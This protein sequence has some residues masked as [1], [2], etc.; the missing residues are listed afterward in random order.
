MLPV[1]PSNTYLQ[2]QWGKPAFQVSR[3]HILHSAVNVFLFLFVFGP[4][5]QRWRTVEKKECRL[6]EPFC[7]VCRW[8]SYKTFFPS[9]MT[10]FLRSLGWWNEAQRGHPT[11]LC[12]KSGPDKVVRQ[13]VGSAEGQTVWR[14]RRN[15]MPMKDETCDDES[16]P[17]HS[18]KKK[19]RIQ[20]ENRRRTKCQSWWVNKPPPGD[21]CF[22]FWSDL[23]K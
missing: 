3:L 23:C 2:W 17:T 19:K 18:K 1:V 13:V 6:K 8:L 9:P 7:D 12:T 21:R 16:S 11:Y 5:V 20:N 10:T 14:A 22:L 4:P 15:A